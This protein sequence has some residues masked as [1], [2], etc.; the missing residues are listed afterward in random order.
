[1]TIIFAS[2]PKDLTNKPLDEIENVIKIEK[3]DW[4]IYYLC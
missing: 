4:L 2:Y 3:L 1:M